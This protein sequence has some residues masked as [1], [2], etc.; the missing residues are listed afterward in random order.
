M[1]E[2]MGNDLDAHVS[3]DN[4]SFIA[5]LAPDTPITENAVHPISFDT[6]CC[7]LFDKQS[8]ENLIKR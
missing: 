3:R 7:H 4:H 5:R 1:I 6:Q 2:N 8:G